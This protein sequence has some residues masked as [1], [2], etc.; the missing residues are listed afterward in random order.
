MKVVASRANQPGPYV[1]RGSVGVFFTR[2]ICLSIIVSTAPTVRGQSCL[3]EADGTCDVPA[4]CSGGTDL[5]DCAI[6]CPVTAHDSRVPG[7]IV[8]AS[9]ATEHAFLDIA[10]TGAKLLDPSTP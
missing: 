10:T 9:N 4:R 8:Y 6:P 2:L 1:L 5:V 3:W 7:D